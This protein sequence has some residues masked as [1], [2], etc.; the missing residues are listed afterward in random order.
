MDELDIELPESSS[1]FIKN[2]IED[3]LSILYKYYNLPASK[4]LIKK[5][6][7]MNYRFTL[8]SSND[9]YFFIIKF[10]YDEDC[11][12]DFSFTHHE[13]L[14]GLFSKLSDDIKNNKNFEFDLINS[15]LNSRIN[16]SLED[17]VIGYKKDLIYI[18]FKLNENNY[19][20]IYIPVNNFNR[21]ELCNDL[22]LMNN[23][24]SDFEP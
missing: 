2:N 7:S 6:N 4:F 21:D 14:E 13:D 15:N 11:I 22:N 3:S 24:Y 9:P 10:F 16:K 1:N 23:V 19:K 20:N 18:N 17:V 8:E 5:I 12:C